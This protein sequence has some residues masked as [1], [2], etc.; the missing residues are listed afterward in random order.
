MEKNNYKELAARAGA[1]TLFALRLLFQ[2]ILGQ[3]SVHEMGSGNTAKLVL[4]PA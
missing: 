1:F 2:E 4:G 3:E